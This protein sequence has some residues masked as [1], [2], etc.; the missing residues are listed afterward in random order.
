M[1]FSIDQ[2]QPRL[3][4]PA[5]AAGVQPLRWPEADLSLSTCAGVPEPVRAYRLP[6]GSA[7]ELVGSDGRAVRRLE[8]ATLL[9]K[10]TQEAARSCGGI[11][12]WQQPAAQL[13]ASVVNDGTLV[14]DPFAQRVW[15]RPGR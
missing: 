11:G 5:V 1:F 14:V 9:L 15:F 10:D 4:R 2:H 12:T 8:G 13:G 3:A 7:L 6:Q